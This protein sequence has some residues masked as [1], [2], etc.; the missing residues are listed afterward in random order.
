MKKPL[1]LLLLLVGG[2]LFGQTDYTTIPLKTTA[3]CKA[4]EPAVLVAANFILGKPLNDKDVKDPEAFVLT[5]MTN[6]EY[7]FMV[8]NKI[9]KLEKGNK[10]LLF[11]YMS[12]QAKYLLENVDKA[13]DQNAI[14]VGAYSLLADYV[15]NAANGV[16]M[17]KDIQKLIDAKK[18]GKIQEWLDQK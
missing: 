13:K 2:F 1:T 5:W 14:A 4:A 11:V 15:S 16:K 7:S 9:S 3:D 6:T 10:N 18:N 8:D 17:N 12:C